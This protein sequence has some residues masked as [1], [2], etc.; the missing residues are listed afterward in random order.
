MESQFGY[1]ISTL[2]WQQFEVE[3]LK[4]YLSAEYLEQKLNEFHGLKQ[5]TKIVLEYEARFMEFLR[6]DTYMHTK[7]LKVNKFL[8]GLNPLLKEKVCILMPTTLH[9]AMQKAIIAEEE[10][11]VSKRGDKPPNHIVPSF[12]GKPPR[13]G[14]KGI[15]HKVG[16]SYQHGF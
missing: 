8:Y 9:E 14:N 15:N 3:F 7:S 16:G 5:G 13:R 10:M 11:Q 2:T 6:Y 4:K 1:S 12:H